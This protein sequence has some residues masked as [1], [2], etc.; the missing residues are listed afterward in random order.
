[1]FTSRTFTIRGADE[2]VRAVVRQVVGANR[3]AMTESGFQWTV[4]DTLAREAVV[5]LSM[6]FPNLEWVLVE[7]C[8]LTGTT[9]VT[10]LVNGV[11]T[12]VTARFDAAD[13][14]NGRADLEYV[15]VNRF[16]TVPVVAADAA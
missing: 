11:G 13:P 7:D 9:A 12:R 15:Q 1:M 4:R 10:T 16:E 2:D 14:K 6:T 5:L 8:P 3:G